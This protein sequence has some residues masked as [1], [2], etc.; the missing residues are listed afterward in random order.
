VRGA[1]DD[2][3]AKI[4]KQRD[5]VV[6][7][8][9][10]KDPAVVQAVLAGVTASLNRSSNE[11][12]ALLTAKA[13]N[14]SSGPLVKAAGPIESAEQISTAA[15]NVSVT[16]VALGQ[17]LAVKNAIP[18]PVAPVALTP[19]QELEVWVRANAI[20]FGENTAWRNTTLAAKVLDE[21]A[22]RIKKAGTLVRVVGYTDQT[23]IAD[24]NTPLSQLRADKVKEELIARGVPA[25][26]LVAFG[27]TDAR[28]ISPATGAGSPNRRVE[29]EVGFEGEQA[30]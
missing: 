25:S 17:A 28:S 21:A 3:L 26:I 10:L 24:K 13:T 15:E 7:E 27:R 30:P 1:L 6:A 20:F 23:G 8:G 12:G 19:R 11:L 29:F 18:A 4:L 5:S 9:P 22:A 2:G 14:A 16:L